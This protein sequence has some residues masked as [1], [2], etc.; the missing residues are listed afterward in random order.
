[1]RTLFDR[2]QIGQLSLQNRF[3]R[4]AV[5][6]TTF[7]G[8]VND[9]AVKKYA[10]LAEGGVG[11]IIT[12]MSLVDGEESLL[13]VVAFCSDSFVPGHRKLTESVHKYDTRIIAQLAYIGSYMSVGGNGGLIALAPSSVSNIVTG[14]PAREMRIGEIKLIQKKFADAAYRAREAGYDGVEIHSAHGLLLSQF[15]TPHYNQRT[16]EYGG[17]VENRVRMLFE[18]YSS[19][20]RATGYDFP[21]WVKLNSTDGI[22]DGITDGDF[23]DICYIMAKAGVDAIEVSGNWTPHASMSGAYF[24]DAAATAADDN[25]DVPVILTGGNR[26]VQEM[27]EILNETKI[28]F[29]GIAR[30]FSR[31]SGLIERYKRECANIPADGNYPLTISLSAEHKP[32][33]LTNM[34]SSMPRLSL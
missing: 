24:K 32:L 27:T 33:S 7:D 22:E 6:D 2:S 13:P 29:F 11:A 10:A 17:P 9:D 16:D 23:R 28:Q 31:E 3:I 18:V 14:T 4:A 30:P 19:M 5:T 12:G 34:A 26:K 21:I 20:R 15:L 1:M 8:Y 25:D